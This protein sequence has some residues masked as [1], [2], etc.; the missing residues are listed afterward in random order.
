LY[1]GKMEGRAVDGEEVRV[2][3]VAVVAYYKVSS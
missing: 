2:C 3:K 1:A